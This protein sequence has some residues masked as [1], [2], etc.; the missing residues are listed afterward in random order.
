MARAHS[1]NT[2]ARRR[3][4][5]D[6]RRIGASPVAILTP[7]DARPTRIRTHVYDGAHHEIR[8]GCAPPV[9]GAFRWVE[10]AGLADA[11]AIAAAARA[12]GLSD[13][14][15]AEIFQT[16]QRPQTEIDGALVQTFIRAPLGGPP[17]A[18]EQL[19]LVLGPGFALSV[20]ES[21]HELFA[22][23]LRR[24]EAGTG[25]IRSDPAYLFYALIDATL[26]A[27]FPLLERYGDAM[28]RIEEAILRSPDHGMIGD[29]HQLRRDLLN[30]RRALWP[31]R[32]ALAPLTR[33]D[34]DRI[35]PWMRPYMRD[36][37]DHAFQALDM[38]EL[39]REVSQGL[40]DLHMSALSN[41]MNEV[42][43]VLTII[44]TLF[45]PMTFIAGVYGMN[46]D[47]AS[48][49]NMPELGWRYGYPFALG[50]MGASAAAM[51]WLFRR[52]GWLGGGKGAPPGPDKPTGD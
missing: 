4:R 36:L 17:L 50:L 44:A 24:L 48:P 23:V 7:P 51:I 45:I 26:D 8:E 46:F 20:S 1:P 42:M 38:V 13:L 2:Q 27:W 25:R 3:R 33:E 35:P 6:P 37:S 21:G 34:S 40:I 47:R 11:D 39:Y 14:A 52:H 10:I 32:D 49:W 15:V 41:R 18:G 9:E 12:L 29:I 43:K 30:M 28:E 16:D 31:L 5:I 19:C 22:P